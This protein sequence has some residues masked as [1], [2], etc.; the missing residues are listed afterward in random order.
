MKLK[1]LYLILLSALLSCAQNIKHKPFSQQELIDKTI[2]RLNIDRLQTEFI[3]SKVSPSNP[4]ETIIV[5]PVIVNEDESSYELDSH[6][7]ILNNV[8]GKMTH[9]FFENSKTNGWISNAEFIYDITIDS[10]NYRLKASEN[11]FGVTAKFRTMS[12]PNPYYSESF[13]LYTKHGSSLKKVLDSYSVFESFGEVNVNSCYSN[14]EKTTN[15]LFMSN[16]KTNGYNDILVTVKNSTIHHFED[17]NGDC[18]P[19]ETNN[20]TTKRLLKFN[21]ELY[22]TQN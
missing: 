19:K 11:A 6:I 22:K 9:A 10:L 17:K 18:I 8:T 20:N 4:K 5:I 12:Q 7:V 13:S 3:I 2:T 15:E 1:M 14:I 21:G 16:S